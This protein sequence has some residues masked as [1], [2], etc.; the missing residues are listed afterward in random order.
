MEMSS[1]NGTMVLLIATS[2]LGFFIELLS[3]GFFNSAQYGRIMLQAGFIAFCYSFVSGISSLF[4]YRLT[5][6]SWGMKV[7]L[8]IGILLVVISGLVIALAMLLWF[9]GSD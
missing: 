3:G 2:V 5:D 8:T 7:C 1:R 9:A 6:R 4:Y